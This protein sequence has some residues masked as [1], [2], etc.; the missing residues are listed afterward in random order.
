MQIKPGPT[1]SGLNLVPNTVLS[2]IIV[3]IHVDRNQYSIQADSTAEHK[4]DNTNTYM[5]SPYLLDLLCIIVILLK[6]L[7]N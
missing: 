1:Q 6:A 2:L 3:E 4:L 5:A 7:N